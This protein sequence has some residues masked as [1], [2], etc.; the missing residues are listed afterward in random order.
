LPAGC[1]SSLHINDYI[2]ELREPEKEN[3]ELF[4]F[5]RRRRFA[6]GKGKKPGVEGKSLVKVT[7]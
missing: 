3:K 5:F 7:K 2:G 4:L 1:V 6:T